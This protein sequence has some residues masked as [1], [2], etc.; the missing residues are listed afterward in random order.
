MSAQERIRRLA[1]IRYLARERPRSR[2]VRISLLAFA[3][4]TAYAW[5]SGEV[6]VGDLLSQRRVANVE[7][8]LFDEARPPFLRA[9][10]NAWGDAPAWFSSVLSERGLQGA[11][12]T[13][14]IAVIAM[15]LAAAAALLL[16]AAAAR[17]L[18]TRDPYLDKAG[19]QRGVAR[20]VASLTRF[21]LIVLRA[22][23]EYV[24]AFLL[25]AVLGPTAWPVVIALA[26]HNAG[27]LGR[28]GAES[29]E[30]L[31]PSA[32]ASLA[33]VGG[34]RGQIYWFAALPLTMNRAL[35]FFFYRLETCVREATVLGMLGVLS[36]GYWIQDARSRLLYDEMLLL[37][38][39]AS[40]MVLGVDILSHW[41]RKRLRH[42]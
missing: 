23:P 25:L 10:P 14:W 9:D 17:S 26:L 15:V 6:A 37:V 3:A 8:F 40:G 30:N 41:L 2:L 42:G 1:H 22:I 29:I 21:L 7:R 35:L 28:L 11:L 39:V 16:Q 27:I 18:M 5:T 31:E 4:A 33:M 24:W 34:R 13:L 32:L 12:Q 19:K 36:L 20:V 38:A